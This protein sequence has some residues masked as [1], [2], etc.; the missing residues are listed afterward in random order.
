[1]KR[2]QSGGSRRAATTR[3]EY[4]FSNTGGIDGEPRVATPVR[5]KSG[6]VEGIDGASI[7]RREEHLRQSKGGR[8]F[9][10]EGAK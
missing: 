3:Q 4:R 9:R 7:K 2:W 1:L 6:S 8:L 10:A 5:A